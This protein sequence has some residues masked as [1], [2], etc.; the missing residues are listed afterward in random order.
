MS[1]DA[2]AL[3]AKPT[4]PTTPPPIA[5]PIAA[6]YS[7]ATEYDLMRTLEASRDPIAL[8]AALRERDWRLRSRQQTR[9]FWTEAFYQETR[10]LRDNVGGD[11]VTVGAGEYL[12][13][14]HLRVQDRVERAHLKEAFSIG[15]F[16][17]TEGEFKR[18]VDDGGYQEATFWDDYGWAWRSELSLTAPWLWSRYPY[19]PERSRYPMAGV[20]Y[21]EAMAFC[22]WRAASE[23]AFKEVRLASSME[24]EIAARGRLARPYPWGWA[25]DPTRTNLGGTQYN[26]RTP[27]SRYP[28]GVSPLGCWDMAGNV[29]ELTASPWHQPERLDE[30][31]RRVQSLPQNPMLGLHVGVWAL[32][33]APVQLRMLGGS[34]RCGW[35]DVRIPSALYVRPDERVGDLGFRLVCKPAPML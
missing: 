2:T 19:V 35:Q 25:M 28:G 9:D 1:T 24:W 23:R 18:F 6:D 4:T 16:P 29:R 14:D 34:Y 33:M 15:R 10:K 12:V 21:F 8:T 17:V 7:A 5:S 20:S 31:R 22:R 3:S 32:C 27:V 26:T 13:G 30:V 11:F